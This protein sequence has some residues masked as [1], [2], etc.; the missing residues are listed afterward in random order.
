MVLSKEFEEII[1]TLDTNKY[2]VYRSI[3]FDKY[4]NDK[5][6]VDWGIF[7]KDMPSEQYFSSDNKPI[8]NSKNNTLDELINFVKEK[9]NAKTN[10]KLGGIK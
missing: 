4:T 2:H 10:K 8:L 7:D 1:R 5:Y 9:A 6:V 3:V